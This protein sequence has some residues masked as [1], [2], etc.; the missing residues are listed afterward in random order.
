[1]WK[2]L[3]LALILVVGGWVAADGSWAYTQTIVDT[4]LAQSFKDY[5]PINWSGSEWHDVIGDP[6]GGTPFK[7]GFDVSKVEVTWSGADVHLK[8]FSNFPAGGLTVG[9]KATGVADLFID[10]NADGVGSLGYYDAVVKMSGPEVGKVYDDSAAWILTYSHYYFGDS[11]L[12][13]GGRY[14]AAALKTPEVHF[15]GTTVIGVGTVT[16][17]GSGPYEINI[18]LPGINTA[19]DWNTFNFV[20]NTANCANESIMGTAMIPLPASLWLV[21]TGLLGLVGWR[22]LR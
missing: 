20:W 6:G 12:I 17:I 18:D 22:R 15:D 11:G 8:F 4:T 13:Y 9:G 1:M 19:G 7:D 21:G 10:R 16:W 14:D 5:T 3:C 2:V